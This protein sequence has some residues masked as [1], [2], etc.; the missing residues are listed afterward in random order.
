[1][2][3]NHLRPCLKK[4]KLPLFQPKYWEATGFNPMNTR[5]NK[6][7]LFYLHSIKGSL[8]ILL[9]DAIL[10]LIINGVLLQ[11]SP[12]SI[13]PEPFSYHYFFLF[14]LFLLSAILITFSINQLYTVSESTTP[15]SLAKKICLS[16]FITCLSVFTFGY[17]S[18]HFHNLNWSLIPALLTTFI[19]LFIFRYF[20]LF[21]CPKNRSRVLI[22][23]ANELSKKI[24]EVNQKRRFKPYEIIGLTSTN[25]QMVNTSFHGTP[26]LGFIDDLDSIVKQ[27]R[28]DCIVVALRNRRGKL[29]V[30]IL[31]QIKTS[32][33]RIMECTTFYEQITQKIVVDEFLKPSWFIFEEGFSSSPIYKS[34]K[35]IQGF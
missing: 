17:F 24:I 18:P 22:L 32:G 6:S 21:N 28:P 35:R 19:C 1:M 31:L 8:T 2:M 4:Q 25:A 26:V 16:F 7:S 14:I 11:P 34:I 9:A 15:F 30:R 27:Y 23:G 10:I 29:P 3:Q 20:L 33:I 5:K 13:N 12:L